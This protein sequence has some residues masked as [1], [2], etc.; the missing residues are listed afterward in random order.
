[1][2]FNEHLRRGLAL[3]TL[4]LFFI[5]C[6]GGGA[7]D[8]PDLGQVSGV[9][10]MDGKP[11]EGAM[12]T[13]EP[14]GA[15]AS[16]G[17]TDAEGKFTLSYLNGKQGAAIGTHTVRVSVPS[18][19]DAPDPSYQ[20]PVPPTYNINSQMTEDVKAGDNEFTFELS[21]H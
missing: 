5:G 20:D 8:A 17:K 14:T 3:I 13:F 6:G 11:L 1:M 7:S 21:S 19:G 12:V 4:S 16:M 15:A 2:S 18:P 9:V 10:T